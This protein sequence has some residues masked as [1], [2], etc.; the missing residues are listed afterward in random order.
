MKAPGY[1]A[2][3]ERGPSSP[4]TM[5]FNQRYYTPSEGRV[6][7]KRDRLNYED[8]W[9]TEEASLRSLRIARTS[10]LYRAES[11]D[12]HTQPLSLSPLANKPPTATD[13]FVLSTLFPPFPRERASIS[14]PAGN[15]DGTR[16]PLVAEILFP[17]AEILVRA[18]SFRLN[19]PPN[20]R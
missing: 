9:W 16:T 12:L 10:P 14:A 19:D 7:N 4:Q 17:A 3:L 13:P 18:V 6:L 11:P 5:S 2:R 20:E 1:N 15:T 8:I